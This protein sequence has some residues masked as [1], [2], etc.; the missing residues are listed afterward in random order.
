MRNLIKTFILMLMLSFSHSAFAG[1]LEDGLA[2]YKKQDFSIAL[3]LW[4][5]LAEK[6]NATAQSYLGMMYTKGNGVAQDY[7]TGVK[8]YSLAA[9]QG[10]PAAQYNLGQAYA[11]GQ[12]V[13][14]DYK[15]AFKW[16]ERVA[17]QGLTSAQYNLGVMYA[18]GNGITVDYFKAHVWFNIAAIIGKNKN[19]ATNRDIV[20]KQM[21]PAQIA[22]AQEAA[23]R[24]IKQNFKNCD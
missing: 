1:D 2:A 11:N 18:K 9:D 24:C 19:A 20:E 10:E 8:W 12:G 13:A 14:Q 17:E 22:Q 6:G 15:T 5:P 7:K 4:T 23:T 16:F 21:T 3:R